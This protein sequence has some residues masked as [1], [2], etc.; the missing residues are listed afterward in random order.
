MLRSSITAVI[1]ASVA[2]CTSIREGALDAY[3]SAIPVTGDQKS[4]LGG[5]GYDLEEIAENVFRI[6]VK[7]TGVTEPVRLRAIAFS[8]AIR[9]AD[10]RGF[11]TI[12]I[13]SRQSRIKCTYQNYSNQAV[14][15]RYA[16]TVRLSHEPGPYAVAN[17]PVEEIRGPVA[18]AMN[19]ASSSKAAVRAKYMDACGGAFLGG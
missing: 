15:P 2:A 4:F 19:A 6:Q 8:Q 16:L 5:G 3:A 10:E 17:I 11:S 7:A 13:A 14:A 9:I 18:D 1:L 12:Q